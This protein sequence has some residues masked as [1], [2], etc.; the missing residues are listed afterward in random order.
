MI[1]SENILSEEKREGQGVDVDAELRLS[2]Y[3]EIATINQKHGV[4][5]VQHLETKKVFVKKT[6]T[7]YDI[8]VFRYLM[9]HPVPGIP[10]IEELVETEGRLY[11]LEEYVSGISLQERL[12]EGPLE[13]EEALSYLRQ[14]CEILRPLHRLEPPIV[15]R[16]IK[17]ANIIITSQKSIYLVDF[18]SAKEAREAKGRDTVLIGTVG[19]AA[20]EQYG[21]SASQPTADIYALGVLLNEMLTGAKPQEKRAP[22]PYFSIVDRCLQME[23]ANRYQNVDQLL[24]EIDRVERFRHKVSFQWQ[25]LLPPGFRSR[26]PW[27]WLL[28]LGWYSLFTALSFSLTVEGGSPFKVTAYRLLCFLIFLAETFWLG[29]YQKIWEYFPLSRSQ[30]PLVRAVGVICWAVVIFF[31]LVMIAALATVNQ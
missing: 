24:K 28:A 13:E 1:S 2:F 3:R 4:T 8:E 22:E 7:I 23:P 20:P 5:L 12:G 31:V 14:L 6:L 25:A 17:P 9:D 29:N 19:Y 30:S 27:R 26:K 10:H 11:V 18:N 16:D 15:H 21:F